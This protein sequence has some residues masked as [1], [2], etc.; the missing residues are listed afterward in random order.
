MCITHKN[1]SVWGTGV[2]VYSECMDGWVLKVEPGGIMG[3]V[4]GTD[5]LEAGCAV[6]CEGSKQVTGDESAHKFCYITCAKKIKISYLDVVA[7]LL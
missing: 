4:G 7:Q 6:L 1:T 2:G 5:T 3:K